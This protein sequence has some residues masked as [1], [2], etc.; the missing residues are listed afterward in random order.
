MLRKFRK[1][2]IMKNVILWG[3]IAVFILFVFV[4]WGSGKISGGVQNTIMKIDDVTIDVASFEKEY[5]QQLDMIREQL[6]DKPITKGLIERIGLPERVLQSMEYSVVIRK[7]AEK[8]NI[9]VTDE[10]LAEYIENMPVFQKNGVFVGPQ[11]YQRRVITFYRMAVPRF[12]QKMR[13]FLLESKLKKVITASVRVNDEEVKRAYRINNEKFTIEYAYYPYEDV[14]V[15]PP[16]EE[17]AKKFFQKNRAR[18]TVPEKRKGKFVMISA[19]KL[20]DRVIVTP[21]EIKAYYDDNKDLFSYP[22]KYNFYKILVKT[23]GDLKKALEEL[24]KGKD[25]SAVAKEI[26]K[27]PRAKNGGY[28]KDIPPMF[29][30]QEEKG[31]LLRANPGDISPAL[32]TKNGFE[33]IKLESKVPGGVKSLDEVRS[34]IERK[35]KMDK[36]Y[37]LASSLAEKLYKEAKKKGLKEAAKK[38]GYEIKTTRF[39]EKGE[40]VEGDPTGTVST[41]LFELEKGKL[42]P[43]VRSYTGYFVAQLDEIQPQRQGTYNEFAEKVKDELKRER[44]RKKAQE[45]LASAIKTGKFLPVI[46][47][48]TETLTY[49]QPIEGVDLD[50]EAYRSML[51]APLNK[52]SRVF[53][54]KKGAFVFRILSRDLDEARMQQELP[55]FKKQ[56]LQREKDDFYKAF[57]VKESSQIKIRFNQ[58]AFEKAKKEIIGR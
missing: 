34:S 33:I 40:P 36:A 5:Y 35:L 45:I 52:W 7:I 13:E 48:K 1:S 53:A 11:E 16:T 26:S 31:W 15:E 22:E 8:F 17:E 55:R 20:Q 18:Y 46:I 19:F 29:L 51:D 14:D 54:L 39:V 43:P 25:F 41:K 28:W 9:Q 37:E 56:M 2:K 42:T 57:L 27:G 47:H 50:Y 58:K 6:G 4:A 49:R 38:F 10:E 12:E 44:A 3:V 24:K 23:E 30:Q 32:K 21:K